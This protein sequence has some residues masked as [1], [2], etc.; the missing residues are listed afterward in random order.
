MLLNICVQKIR[1]ILGK[2]DLFLV[3][4]LTKKEWKSLIFVSLSLFFLNVYIFKKIFL[5]VLSISPI[6]PQ[7]IAD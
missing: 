3:A 2:L 4:K 1:F 6:N 7:L 5:L